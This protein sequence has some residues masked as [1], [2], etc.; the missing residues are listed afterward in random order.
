VEDAQAGGKQ[1]TM[2][3]ILGQIADGVGNAVADVR[4]KVLEEGWFGRATT[5]EQ[6]GPG[7][8]NEVS[9]INVSG[10]KGSDINV[11][12]NIGYTTYDERKEAGLTEPPRDHCVEHGPDKGIDR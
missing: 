4:H 7:P 9:S 6:S 3:E 10:N 12:I 5:S 8:A 11:S 1:M 2:R